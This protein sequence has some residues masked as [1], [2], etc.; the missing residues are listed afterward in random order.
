MR[1]PE[2]MITLGRPAAQAPEWAED[3]ARR[4]VAAAHIKAKAEGRTFWDA[5][6]KVLGAELAA[7]GKPT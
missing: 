3:E 5:V 4:I 1:A 2:E 6:V 7:R